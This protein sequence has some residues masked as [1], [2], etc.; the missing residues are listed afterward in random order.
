MVQEKAGT[1]Q[2]IPAQLQKLLKPALRTLDWLLP[3]SES[4]PETVGTLLRSVL[5]RTE[6]LESAKRHAE[7]LQ[8]ELQGS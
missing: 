5:S 7:Q 1:P 8:A 4:P 6:S 2:E 3:L